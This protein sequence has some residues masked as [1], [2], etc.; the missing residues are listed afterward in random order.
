MK[1]KG[2]ITKRKIVEAA[3]ELF[4]RKSYFNTSIRDILEATGLTKGGLYGHFTSKEDIWYA[5]YDEAAK[6]WRN[7]TFEGTQAIE[8]PM[9]RIDRV[10][11]NILRN[12][13]GKNVF[14]GGGF[15]VPHLMEF[16]GQAPEMSAHILEGF[17]RYANLLISWV[18]EADEKGLLAPDLNHRDIGQFIVIAL[19][20]AVTLYVATQDPNVWKS[21]ISQLK[22]YVAHLRKS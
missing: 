9:E 20:G 3:I 6:R 13:I 5:A 19:N 18:E 8:D 4:T 11:D 14:H 1:T 12:Y 21:S 7:I 10:I 22:F 15:F 17:E 2:E 16:S